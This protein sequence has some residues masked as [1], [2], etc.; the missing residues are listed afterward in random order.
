MSKKEEYQKKLQEEL[1]EWGRE[2]DKLKVLADKAKAGLKTEY[3]K[4]VLD[5]KAKRQAAQ[6]KLDELKKESGEAWV[7][8][9]GGIEIAWDALG[10]AVKSAASRFK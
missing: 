3:Q 9:K 2:I 10:K 7:D 6:G 8:L 5:L 1:D 4:E